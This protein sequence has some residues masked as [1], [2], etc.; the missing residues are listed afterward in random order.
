VAL[1]NA[2]SVAAS[3][4]LFAGVASAQTVTPC[5]NAQSCQ[6]KA[7]AG[8]LLDGYVTAS[9]AGYLFIFNSTTVPANGN[10]SAG[11][12]PGSYQ[13]CLY[14]PSAGT[15]GLT[16]AGTQPETFAGP[17]AGIMMVWSSTGCGTLTL[18]TAAFLKGRV[19]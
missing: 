8:T 7:T 18:A 9:G 19:Q 14:L 11:T 16:A 3:L 4:A 6:L 2:L 17:G 13:D 1:V 15:F 10:V 12:A 5:A